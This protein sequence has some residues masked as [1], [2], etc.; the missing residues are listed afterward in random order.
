M[1]RPDL[2]RHFTA[3]A[4]VFHNGKVLLAEHKKMGSWL[5]LGGHIEANETP[6]EAVRREVKEE[7]GID[8]SFVNKIDCSLGDERASVLHKPFEILCETIDIPNDKHYHIDLIYL[9]KTDTDKIK[10]NERESKNIGWFSQQEIKNL[11]LFP[12]FRNLLKK[13]FECIKRMEESSS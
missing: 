7:A 6:E 4:L 12:N 5:F 13:A 10:I 9:C 8:V 2:K 11:N 3:S 1:E